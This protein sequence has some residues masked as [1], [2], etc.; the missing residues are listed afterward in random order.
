MISF[1]YN[2]RDYGTKTSNKVNDTNGLLMISKL[3][4]GS[5]KDAIWWQL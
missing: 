2:R 5:N 4:S 1:I 3:P